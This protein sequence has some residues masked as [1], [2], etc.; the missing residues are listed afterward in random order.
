MDVLRK[1]FTPTDQFKVLCF[2]SDV[3]AK[4]REDAT[5]E[6]KAGDIFGLYCT[7]SFR[8]VRHQCSVLGYRNRDVSLHSCC[9]GWTY[10]I[11]KSL[12]SGE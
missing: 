4:L 6:F 7:D 10:L 5:A 1:Q 11:L 8:M 9:R 3:T 12:S 2:N